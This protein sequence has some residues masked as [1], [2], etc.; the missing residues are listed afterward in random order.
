MKLKLT[1]LAAVFAAGLTA[2]FALANDGHGKGEDHG[3]KNG[4]C[5]EVHLRGTIAAQTLGV[6]LDKASKKLGSA[7]GTTVE[8][9]LGAAGQ[10]VRVD[11]QACQVVSGTSTVIQVRE[12]HAKVRTPKATTTT[13]AA[14][15]TAPATTTS[16]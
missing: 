15:T 10:T 6:T 2:S 8:V 14:T 5:T 13:A 11:A 4:K 1:I 3:N 12:L 7:A 16:P 9:A